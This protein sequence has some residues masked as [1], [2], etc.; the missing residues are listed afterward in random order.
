MCQLLA[1]SC[2]EPATINFSLEGFQ[3]RGGITDEHKDGW[4]I[5]FYED[6]GHRIFRDHEP[7]STSALLKTIKD[8]HIKSRTVIAH[9]RKATVGAVNL[10]NC[11]PFKREL[12]GQT[13]IFCHNGDLP[14]YHPSLNGSFTPEGETDSER[15]FCY[16]MESLSKRFPDAAKDKCPDNSELYS[17]L[18]QL[19]HEIAAY[20]IFNILLSNG[21]ML[22]THC[23][24]NLSYLTRSYPF[25]KATLID[26][27]MN[28]DLSA[29]NSRTNRMV[30]ITTKP[31]TYNEP[32]VTCQ[33][34]EALM[35]REGLLI[36]GSRPTETPSLADKV[37]ALVSHC[38]AKTD[39]VSR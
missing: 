5:A 1:M 18:Q 19:S 27:A 38:F 26:C 34:S 2:K 37:S 33:K 7:A 39:L 10:R 24:T 8:L 6:Q 31:L 30:I 13:W 32:W 22:F 21:D 12:W 25:A 4:G 20:G 11:H 29:H 16:L 14:D 28:M 17:A 9:I 36:A 23:S 15:A 35:F 3:A